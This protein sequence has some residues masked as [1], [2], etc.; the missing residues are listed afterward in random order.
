MAYTVTRAR[1]DANQGRIV[2]ALR[3]AG[4]SVQ[5][6]ATIGK[7]CPDLLVGNDGR[8]F[9]LEAKN[10]EY[11]CKSDPGKDLTEDEIEWVS[12]WVGG[13]V[14]VVYGEEEALRAVCRTEADVEA[15]LAAV[16]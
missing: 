11:R 10:P 3:G 8:T 7:G 9:L 14:W 12:K 2:A 5:S 4:C 6:L 1:V 16:R 13:R 15:G